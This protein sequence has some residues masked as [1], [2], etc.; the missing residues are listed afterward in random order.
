MNET[1]HEF[2]GRFEQV[3]PSVELLLQPVERRLVR[4]LASLPRED[5][6]YK[7]IDGITLV[8]KRRSPVEHCEQSRHLAQ[9]ADPLVQSFTDPQLCRTRTPYAPKQRRVGRHVFN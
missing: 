1:R 2:T 7:L 3:V 8:P 5:D 6:V 9:I 4:I